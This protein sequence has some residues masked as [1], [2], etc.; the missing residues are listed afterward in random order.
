MVLLIAPSLSLAKNHLAKLR[1]ILRSNP[2]TLRLLG[3]SFL[4]RLCGEKP[5]HCIFAY[6]PSI[7]EL[8]MQ[9][10]LWCILTSIEIFRRG[11]HLRHDYKVTN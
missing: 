4:N 6:V 3:R 5:I 11:G 2:T 1:G 9:H 8:T 10:V 7:D